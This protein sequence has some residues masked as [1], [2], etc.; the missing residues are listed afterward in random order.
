MVETINSPRDTANIFSAFPTFPFENPDSFIKAFS[1]VGKPD[2]LTLGQM[3]KDQ[4]AKK[5]LVVQNNE[6]QLYIK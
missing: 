1:A 3:L 2:T 6:I 5:F 4:D